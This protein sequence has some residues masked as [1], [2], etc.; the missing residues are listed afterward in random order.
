MA[1]RKAAAEADLRAGLFDYLFLGNLKSGPK[2]NV[3]DFCMNLG[4]IAS[5]YEC[6]KCGESMRLVERSD[7]DGGWNWV[8]RVT[9]GSNKHYIK[10]SIRQGSWFDESKLSLSE[11]LMITYLWV[12]KTNS[13]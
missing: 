11:I 1:C 4:W 7:V 8:C 5:K 9:E 6:V 3:V 13:D 2:R 10:R 12:K